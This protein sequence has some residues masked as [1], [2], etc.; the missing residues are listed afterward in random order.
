MPE[1][2]KP[3]S[4]TKNFSW[5]KDTN[6]LVELYSVIRNGFADSL[7]DVPRRQFRERIQRS[8]RPDYIPINFFLF[9]R[10]VDG[11]DMI[12]ADELVFQA[13]SWEHSPAFD[14][15][16]LFAFL[17]S[18]SGRWKGATQHQRRPAMWANAYVR[19]RVA[20]ELGW[21]A[22]KITANDIQK[23]V[24]NDP[25]Y[26]AETTRKLSTNLNFLLHIG[27][28]QDFGEKRV[29]RWWVDCLFLAL[30]RLLEDLLIDG[31]EVEGS[32]YRSL[33]VRS[34][35]LEL[36]GGKTLEKDLATKHL[37]RL[38]GAL[39]GR[40]RF[41]DE[42]VIEKT[43]A[44]IPDAYPA[45]PNDPRPR[46]AVH[47]TNPRILKSIPPICSELAVRAG[48]DVISP[49]EMEEMQFEEFIRHRTDSA[50]A[51]LRE[52]GIRPTLSIEELLSITRGDE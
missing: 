51:I 25:R 16:A 9:N 31:R 1:V 49:D 22:A 26:E 37:V 10:T 45:N 12:C 40:N 32:Q 48:F 7:E 42:A 2:W 6:G 21:D 23:F 43:N 50:I 3:G 30:D 52:R 47:L 8:G 19:E 5:G 39:G 35:F 29:S 20:S 24:T 11:V 17:F 15:V 18:Y 41:S 13:L 4:F 14:R 27:R 28:I 33:L 46:G 34:G 44:E 36:T 38:Y